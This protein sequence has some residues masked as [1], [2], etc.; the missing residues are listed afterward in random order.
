MP[1]RSTSPPFQIFILGL[2]LFALI[3]LAVKTLS[4]MDSE[5]VKIL[6]LADTFVCLAF[7]AD[8]VIHLARA[9]NR[10]RYFFTWGW[11]DL[12]SSIPTLDI[13]RWGR[14]ARVFRIL[15]VLRGLRATHTLSAFLLQRR[16][17]S[18]FWAASLISILTT[19]FAA[20]AVLNLE[21][22]A[23]GNIK[24]GE[25]ALWWAVVTVTTVGYGDFYPITGAG[26]LVATGLIVT[27]IGI[28]GIFTAYVAAAFLA[29]SKGEQEKELEALRGE[30]FRLRQ[31]RQNPSREGT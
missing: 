4:P 25:D 18:A 8:F 9:D 27:G 14:A 1:H 3:T 26:R 12:I 2:S 24:N 13:F 7:F 6:D 5:V 10:A 20:I 11:L 28:L 17:A 31:A 21:R 29:P 30:V 15:Q 16:A 19:V 22:A 23:G